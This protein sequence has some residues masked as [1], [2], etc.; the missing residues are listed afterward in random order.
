MDV[1]LPQ[2]SNGSV[3]TGALYNFFYIPP[4]RPAL[5]VQGFLPFVIHVNPGSGHADMKYS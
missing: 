4:V 5:D 3:A 1:F 2:L